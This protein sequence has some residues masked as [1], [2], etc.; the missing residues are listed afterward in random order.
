MTQATQRTTTASRL[1]RRLK[2]LSAV[3]RV[4]HTSRR[5]RG[6]HDI[7]KVVP[8]T[9]AEHRVVDAIHKALWEAP[10]GDVVERIEA[11][12]ESYLRSSTYLSDED[13][14]KTSTLAG[15]ASVSRSL[16]HA[17]LLHLLVAELQP[18]FAIE[19]GT[20]VGISAAYQAAG[21]SLDARLLTFEYFPDLADQARKT[22]ASVGV[23]RQVEV[24]LGDIKQTLMPTLQVSPVVKYA[25]VDASH[26]YEA[27]LGFTEL[28]LAHAKQ[29]TVVVFDD[30]K[31][32]AGMIRAWQH[33]CNDARFAMLIDLGSI[34]IGVVGP[35]ALPHRVYRVHY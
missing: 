4:L 10:Q 1:L 15:A 3:Q 13:R 6:R 34:G 32:S 17:W 26:S 5:T 21:L 7:G 16:H 31:H 22:F 28:L 19:L 30:I 18:T 9:S 35:V 25:F 23:S 33:I 11:V 29:D 27:T 8:Y 2:A 20:C 12:R 14:G 24:I